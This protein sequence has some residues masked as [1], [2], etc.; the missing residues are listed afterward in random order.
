MLLNTAII[1][2]CHSYCSTLCLRHFFFIQHSSH[3]DR[4]Q[5]LTNLTLF[6]YL[7][8]LSL[9]YQLL[10][11]I[12]NLNTQIAF[13]TWYYFQV[14]PSENV[15]PKLVPNFFSD[16]S[17]E[18]ISGVFVNFLGKISISHCGMS[19]QILDRNYICL[20]TLQPLVHWLSGLSRAVLLSPIDRWIFD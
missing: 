11:S 6:I 15:I 20:L 8:R 17:L 2:L 12:R 16:F 7:F 3:I 19:W 18:L 1:Q 14:I 4:H 9:F 10:R 13:V 5:K